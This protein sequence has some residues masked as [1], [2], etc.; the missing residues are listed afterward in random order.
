ML[1]S[2]FFSH[3]PSCGAQVN[4]QSATAV[5][6]VCQHCQSTLVFKDQGLSISG[7]HSAILEDYTSLQIGSSGMLN[8][9]YFQVIGRLQIQYENVQAYDV[10][11]LPTKGSW[12][13][14]YL[15]FFG[16]K[17][18]W[19]SESNGHFVYLEEQ[20]PWS[21]P[22]LPIY[23]GLKAGVSIVK[24]DRKDFVVSDVREATRVKNAA[25]GELPFLLTDDQVIRVADARHGN[26]FITLDFTED[27]IIPE[28]FAGYGVALDALNMANLRSMDTVKDKA[29]HLKGK[30]TKNDCPSC[31]ASLTWIPGQATHVTCEYCY[32]QVEFSEDVA[33][34]VKVSSM[35]EAQDYHMSLKIGQTARIKGRRW[36][37]MGFMCV[38]EIRAD[39]AFDVVMHDKKRLGMHSVGGL[40]YEYLLFSYPDKFMWLIQTQ[41]DKWSVANTLNKWPLLDYKLQPLQKNNKP[42]NLLY[43]YGGKVEF[44]AGAFYWQV[45]PNDITF[46]T[47]YGTEKQKIS[48]EITSSEMSW[49]RSKEIQKSDLKEWFKH[50][51]DESQWKKKPL[52]SHNSSAVSAGSEYPENAKS[53][54][55]IL[56]IIYFVINLPILW[57][58]EDFDNLFW[59]SVVILGIVLGPLIKESDD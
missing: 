27:D 2:F 59:A 18:A 37:V 48:A 49:S 1:D 56:V 44:A 41:N 26:E 16:G 20:G 3:C 52:F 6:V 25:E 12:N 7:R 10:L 33:T 4:V 42:L 53:L 47:D 50:S 51:V 36:V 46:Y 24:Y 29:G 58:A 19:L 31:G 8:G 40:W 15:Q 43:R 54:A 35:R 30:I 38:S 39:D 57:M 14:W 21:Y 34:L 22:E 55:I 28:L 45:S 5:T 32:S 11:S 13:E 17:T 9:E 23:I